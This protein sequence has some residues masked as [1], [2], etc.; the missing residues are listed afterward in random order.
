MYRKKGYIVAR[1]V[2]LL[3]VL[4]MAFLVAIQTPLVQTR[5]SKVALNQLVA[6]MDG[7][8]QYDELKVMTSGVIVVRNL[9]LIDTHP[10]TEDINE[11]GWA[12][13]D[14]VAQI[15]TLTA[16]FGLSGLF[17]KEGLHM[18]RVTIEGGSFHL[19]SEPGEEYHDN[20]SRIFHLKPTDQPPSRDPLFD[21]KKL[22]VKDF[23]FQINS[24]LPDRGTYKG[25]GIN[26]DDLDIT[27]DFTAYK[28]ALVDAKI[29]GDIE[30]LS[31][32]EK[33]GYV[34]ENLTSSC[35]F[36]FVDGALFEDFVL[37]DA[38]S[39]IRFRSLALKYQSTK[40]FSDFVNLVPLEGD[41]QRSR[42]AL[43]T[44]AYFSG[45]FIDSPTI[46]EVRRGH[47]SGPVC[48]MNIERLVFSETYSGVS[49]TLSA[50]I[51]GLP[52]IQEATLDAQLQDLT[53]TTTGFSRFLGGLAP[54]KPAPDFSSIA[55][56][57]PLTLQV[58]AKG[59]FNNLDLD[60][61]TQSPSGSFNLTG[62]I[63]NA[64]DPLRPID[65]A[66]NLATHELDLGDILGVDMLGTTTL[67][68]R[69]HAILANGGGLPD[70]TLDSLY[71][72]RIHA[73]GQ[74][75]HN[76]RVIGSLHDDTA[77]GRI[78]SN[79]PLLR[80]DL[81][82]LLDLKPKD[83]RARYRV[84]GQI[85]EAN[86]AA[87]GIN[88]GGKLSRVATGLHADLVRLGERFDG[89]FL[90]EGARLMDKEGTHQLGDIQVNA[91]TDGDWQEIHFDA[92]FL[93]ARFRGDRP[94]TSF[95]RDLQEITLRRDLYAL[96]T[97]THEPSG[98]GN[99]TLDAIF[100]D[101]RA[102]MAIFAP[103]AYIADNTSLTLSTTDQDRLDGRISSDRIAFNKNYLRN[104]N[105]LFDNRNG[106]LLGNIVSSELRAGTLAMLNP[107]I[108][109]GADDNRLSLGVHYDNFSGTGGEASINLEGRMYRDEQDGELVIQAHP[110]GSYIMTG[111]DTWT[112]AP[113]DIIKHGQDIRLDH[114]LISNGSQQLLVDG[115]FSPVHSDTLSL[116][117]DRFDLALVNEFLP[118]QF[119]LQ[120]LMNGQA[121]VAS[122]PDK[123]FGMLMDF[124]LDTLR[125]SGVDVGNMTLSSQLQNEG[126]EIGISL[127]DNID[128]R[129]ALRVGG[130]YF[131]QEKRLDIQAGLDRFPLAVA[132][133]FMP[134]IVTDLGGG[135]SGTL[136]V[137][138]SPDDLIP[139]SD[140]L[141]ID[142]A[143]ARLGLTGV[144]YTISGPLRVDQNGVYL[145]R[146]AILDDDSGS[147]IVDGA[148]RYQHLKDFNVDGHVQLSN[149]KVLD[150]PERPGI[151]YYG[152]LRASGTAN[153][154]G[155]LTAL[156]VD[157]DVSTSGIGEVHIAP[158]ASA[159]SSSSSSHK[160]LTFTEPGRELDPY[161]EMLA[162]LKKKEVTPSDI[163]IHGR[164]N[165]QPS[166]N[167]FVEIDKEA[168]NVASVNGQGTVSLTLRPSRAIF[169]LNGDYNISEGTYQF[170]LP[171]L[172]SKN[173]T[174]QR[175]SSVKF[176]GDVM[177][178]ELDIN[179][180]YGLRAS[181]DPM[182]GTGNLSRRPVNCVINVGDRLRAPKLNLSID[183]PDLDP[184]TRM[185]VESALST[186]DKVQ[187][188][189]VSLLLLGTF[190]PD[191]NSGVFNQTA[192][193]YSNVMEIMSGQLNNI[194]QRFKIPVDVGFGYQEMRTGE[195]LF[196]ISVSTE[197][198]D[199]RVILSG[200]FGNRQYSTGSA[201]G[202]FSGDVD[203]QVK[204]DEEGKF[205]F[206]VFSHSADEFTSYLDF[207]QRN[208]IGV[209]FQKEY[210]SFADFA[211]NLFIP[212]RNRQQLD[213]LEAEKF[214]KQVIIQI[215]DES[216]ETVSDP[217][218]AR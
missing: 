155:P 189:F 118:A 134:D 100:H 181:L 91:R 111:E 173:F 113:A 190:L 191:E 210:K 141:R 121:I 125:F 152:F 110:V 62:S 94:V 214:A 119:S 146:V 74:D 104:V 203:L 150:A 174:V 84:D 168:G 5:L 106:A 188:Q 102:L 75:I 164:V 8:V 211:H 72:D 151:S 180:T 122:G 78:Q 58:V 97:D 43:Q 54:D 68:T 169:D 48:D 85:A 57:I 148:L 163:T 95:A 56:N 123:A 99:Y 130:S 131:L 26:F 22:R 50:H 65:L 2:G 195:N 3:A 60:I 202:D 44:L 24:F 186:S 129:D 88:A 197:L 172:L 108:T 213:S 36:G 23:R 175:G 159:A 160:L 77:A 13:A 10:Y 49:S 136:S 170:V 198:F 101:T 132:S 16:T 93:E 27:L 73:L 199:N 12:P 32:R 120:G 51:A 37:R 18:G 178:T 35:A 218:A 171:G 31:A 47:V 6:I 112:F 42:C 216:G 92:P 201:G 165:I 90:M 52:D 70:A 194:L 128:G 46:A 162:S 33:S 79:D 109:L 149:I 25:F 9:K 69:V 196:D 76:I 89:S 28:F 45:S 145:D 39:D 20:L 59:P 107:A 142:D 179:A 184:T 124:R 114:F 176:N 193:L 127:H 156:N 153:A 139:Y 182:L 143:C 41:F 185:A 55:H 40:D 187:K 167:A 11:R 81:T 87:F 103:G 183:V 105:L 1:I 96:Y 204:L 126:K 4:L 15:K 205:R 19:V 147:M 67:R 29:R 117:M 17:R 116:H 115:G 135:I 80:L 208:G 200:N 177:N 38:W 86:L 30:R 98:C 157:A 207:S 83:G 133:A 66:L 63:R 71:I 14:T 21:I 206:N 64:V 144:T 161:E 212:K 140:D 137:T 192:L 215:E 217:N 138:G 61:Q 7:R 53:G 154:R 166:V 34:I 158:S 209:S 82:G